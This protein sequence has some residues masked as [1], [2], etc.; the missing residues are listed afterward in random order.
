MAIG[1]ASSTFPAAASARVAAP[2]L[3]CAQTVHASMPASS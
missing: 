1:S 2:S 3:S